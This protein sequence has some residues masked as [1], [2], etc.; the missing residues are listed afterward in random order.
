[1]IIWKVVGYSLWR[2]G[3]TEYL[4]TSLLLMCNK[5]VTVSTLSEIFSKK[6]QQKLS[7]KLIDSLAD[8]SIEY[9]VLETNHTSH[10][11]LLPPPHYVF[12]LLQVKGCNFVLGGVHCPIFGLRADQDI[13]NLWLKLYFYFPEGLTC[14]VKYLWK[15]LQEILSQA[16]WSSTSNIS[17]SFSKKAYLFIGMGNTLMYPYWV[18]VVWPQSYFELHEAKVNLFHH[19]ST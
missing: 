13:Q 15:Y 16:D 9:P 10:I 18:A 12:H 17:Y 6:Q 2:R 5:A 14:W 4:H 1:M 8:V 19:T 11:W 7:K 3:A